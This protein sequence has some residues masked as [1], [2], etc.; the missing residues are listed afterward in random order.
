MILVLAEEARA[1]VMIQANSAFWGEVR[2][3]TSNSL[4]GDFEKRGRREIHIVVE[5]SFG[6]F[7]EWVL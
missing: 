5:F 6:E 3:K 2:R 4:P 7:G 1:E